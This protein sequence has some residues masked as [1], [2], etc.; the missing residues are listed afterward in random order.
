MYE[1]WVCKFRVEDD[2]AKLYADRIVAWIILDEEGIPPVPVGR[3][4]GPLWNEEAA[5]QMVQGPAYTEAIERAR[6]VIKK[7]GVMS[8][9]VRRMIEQEMSATDVAWAEAIEKDWLSRIFNRF[10]RTSMDDIRSTFDEIS[11]V[12]TQYH[13]EWAKHAGPDAHGYADKAA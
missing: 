1:V 7:S 13:Q 2:P 10:A 8:M 6:K 11:D 4:L 5:Y 12:A 3:S 9:G